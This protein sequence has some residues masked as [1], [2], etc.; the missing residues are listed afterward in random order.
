MNCSNNFLRRPCLVR[1]AVPHCPLVRRARRPAAL[2]FLNFC[3]N[4]GLIS[5]YM[6]WQLMSVDC[7]LLTANC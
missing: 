7:S 5:D 3:K 1:A 6:A 4:Q 2:I